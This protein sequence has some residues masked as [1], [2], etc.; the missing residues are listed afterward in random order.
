[1][2]TSDTERT[3]RSSA[4]TER[5][6]P[7]TER[8]A[9]RC[10]PAGSIAFKY[11]EAAAACALV[12]LVYE[13]FSHGVWSAYMA[14]GFTVPLILGALPNFLIWLAGAKAPKAAAEIL[15]ACGVATLTA[16]CLLKGVLVIYGTT[17]TL[18]RLYLLIGILLAVPG[19]MIYLFQKKKAEV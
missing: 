13:L 6:V 7:E 12:G 18:I 16:G 1:M 10:V 19:A 3:V 11:L 8:R 14:F 17:N 9:V 5:C 2:Y 15:Y 4:I